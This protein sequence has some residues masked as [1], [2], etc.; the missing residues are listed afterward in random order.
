MTQFT[1]G[2]DAA[3]HAINAV[4][5]SSAYVNHRR[6][7]VD[8]FIAGT[9]SS[10]RELQELQELQASIEQLRAIAGSPVNALNE[11]LGMLTGRLE[12]LG[13]ALEIQISRMEEDERYT[14]ELGAVRVVLAEVR[15]IH[16]N[17]S[18]LLSS[19]G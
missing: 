12:Q 8:G 10:G 11:L 14:D 19:R 16:A 15:R 18:G 9:D 1:N 2:N 5:R 3:S 4:V 6:R 17:A 7:C 13:L